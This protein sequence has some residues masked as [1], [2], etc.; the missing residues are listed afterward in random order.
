LKKLRVSVALLILVATIVTTIVLEQRQSNF[1]ESYA[2]KLQKLHQELHIEK[3]DF[4]GDRSYVI[5]DID[6][7]SHPEANSKE[8]SKT[9]DFDVLKVY[10]SEISRADHDLE[11]A[12]FHVNIRAVE[13]NQSSMIFSHALSNQSCTQPLDRA[14]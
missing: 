8:Y 14:S 2:R 1:G 9:L 4:G 10:C 11:I 7:G 3:I 13:N 12:L 5:F 6:L